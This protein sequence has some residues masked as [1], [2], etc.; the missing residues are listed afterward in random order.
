MLNGS[1]PNTCLGNL[2]SIGTFIILYRIFN[3]SRRLNCFVMLPLEMTSHIAEVLSE[4][5]DFLP[6]HQKLGPHA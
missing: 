5:Q 4:T 6:D 3:K 2:L 1:M